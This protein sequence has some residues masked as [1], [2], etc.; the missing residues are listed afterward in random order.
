MPAWTDPRTAPPT[1]LPAIAGVFVIMLAL[2]VFLIAGWRVS[3][4]ALGA[5]LWGGSEVLRRVA[6]A[7]ADEDG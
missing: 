1:L 4:W 2:P 6:L 3:G 5:V 7:S